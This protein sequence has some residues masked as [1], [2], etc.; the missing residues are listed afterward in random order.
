MSSHYRERG[1][2]L[3]ALGL[4]K[5]RHSLYPRS[6]WVTD[7]RPGEDA[8]QVGMCGAVASAQGFAGA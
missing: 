6:A 2:A 3:K 1:C 4:R 7:L 5:T 8:P